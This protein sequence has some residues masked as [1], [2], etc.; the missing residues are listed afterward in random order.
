MQK[1]LGGGVGMS[2]K[3]YSEVKFNDYPIER[4]VGVNNNS[5]VAIWASISDRAV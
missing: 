5:I 4:P 1:E 3:I 2:N